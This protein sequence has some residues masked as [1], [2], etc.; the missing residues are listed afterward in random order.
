MKIVEI[1]VWEN[2]MHTRLPKFIRNYYF[3]FIYKLDFNVNINK[4]RVLKNTKVDT[5]RK[6]VTIQWF[7]DFQQNKNHSSTSRYKWAIQKT[8]QTVLDTREEGVCF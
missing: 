5:W 2:I 1:L 6:V 7:E 4:E 8:Q 3:M